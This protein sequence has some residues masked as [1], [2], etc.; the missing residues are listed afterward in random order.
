MTVGEPEREGR[1]KSPRTSV[2]TGRS[3][4]KDVD[5]RIWLKS[6]PVEQDGEV[7]VTCVRDEL[8]RDMWHVITGFL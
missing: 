6:V 2:L 4:L 5:R 7:R 8:V 1:L 3:F